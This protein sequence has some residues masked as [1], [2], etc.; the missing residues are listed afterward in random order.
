[1]GSGRRYLQPLATF[2][3]MVKASVKDV[4]MNENIPTT[5]AM[6]DFKTTR[7]P[8]RP[9]SVDCDASARLSHCKISLTETFY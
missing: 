9:I 2:N 6:I 1:M 8:G 7:A 4:D 3:W 5:F